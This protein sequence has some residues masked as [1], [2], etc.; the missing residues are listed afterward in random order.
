MY[1]DD[2]ANEEQNMAEI[3]L[4]LDCEQ[5]KS[6]GGPLLDIWD[7]QFVPCGAA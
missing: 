4:K 5:I 3:N 6:A 7:N 2:N 1:L